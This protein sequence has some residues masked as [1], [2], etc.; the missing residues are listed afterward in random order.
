MNYE[1]QVKLIKNAPFITFKDFR[2]VLKNDNSAVFTHDI[3]SLF[4]PNK[5]IFDVDGQKCMFFS[6]KQNSQFSRLSDYDLNDHRLQDVRIYIVD[7]AT[8]EMNRQTVR[9]RRIFNTDETLTFIDPE[10]F[11]SPFRFQEELKICKQKKS[12]TGLPG[13][14][15]IPDDEFFIMYLLAPFSRHSFERMFFCLD[16]GKKFFGIN[17]EIKNMRTLRAWTYDEFGKLK[18]WLF[19]VSKTSIK[20]EANPRCMI[21]ILKFERD[22]I[23]MWNKRGITKGNI[24]RIQEE[25]QR[26]ATEE[27]ERAEGVL[28]KIKRFFSRK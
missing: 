26:L 10:I 3:F 11:V 8:V 25:Y 16:L 13:P 21:E 20:S 1:E 7:S 12:E 24:E 28:C 4:V 19:D 17:C 9:D 15:N 27:R 5:E 23:D 18:E 6:L 2:G 22:L 14:W